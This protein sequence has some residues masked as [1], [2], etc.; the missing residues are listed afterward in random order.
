MPPGDFNG[1]TNP[2]HVPSAF[3]TDLRHLPQHDSLDESR[4]SIT[5]HADFPLTG[6]HIT[7]TCA[8]CHTNNNYTT[9]ADRLL[10]AATRRTSPEPRIR[11]TWLRASPP[12]ARLPHDH[13]WTTSTFN[14]A[15]V[16]PLTGSH[17]T[18][19]A[20]S[21][22][23]T[24][25]L[26][27]RCRRPA[28]AA[29][30]RTTTGPRI[31]RTRRRFP[32]DCDTCHTTTDWTGATFNHN[33]TSFP[34]TGAH[35]TVTCAPCHANNNYTDA[36]DRLLR[37]PPGGL[38][39]DHESQ[40][41]VF[42]LPDRLHHRATP[43]PTGLRRPSITHNGIP[44][45]G[46]HATAC[47]QCHA[48][49]NYTTRCRPPATAATRR[50]T[51]DHESASRHRRLPDRLA[52]PATPPPPGPRDVQP[53]QHVVPADRRAHHRA[54]RICHMNN[55]YT[56]LPTACYGCHQADFTGT[57]NPAHVAAGFPTDCTLCHSTT[58]WTT[59]TFNH[60]TRPSR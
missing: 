24:E 9:T 29:T 57:T 7:V 37:L 18:C 11:R 33:N 30:R 35:T 27:D 45:D 3:P 39:R 2:N 8:Q 1:T 10:L 16:F 15:A 46:L 32:T 41:R 59:S 49:N 43:R 40:S 4:P 50:T 47:A 20:R 56:T 19:I 25:Q 52:R 44:A 6:A 42:G 14:H 17:A 54:L 51:T 13:H 55:N 22:T 5:R 31:H 34:L 53:Q 38:H 12:I 26:H 58:N 60:A 48:N 28:T 23:P 21:A 36:A